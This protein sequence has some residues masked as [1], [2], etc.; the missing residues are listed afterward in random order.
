MHTNT[1][2]LFLPVPFGA[3]TLRNRIVM[4]PLT[5]SRSAANG[6]PGKYAAE[7]Y[8][9]RATAGL[10]IAEAAQI[11]AQG[12]GYAGAPGIYTAAHVRGW[13]MVTHAVHAAGGRIFLQLWHVGRISHPSLQPYGDLPVA[14]SAIQPAGQAF[15][16][17]GFQPFVTPRALTEGELP[18]IVEQYRTAAQRALD[19][20]FDGV[21]IHAANGY[22]ID[23]F[24]RDSTNQ[25][26]DAYGG[27]LEN[28]SRLLMEVTTAVTG[29]WGSH[30]V[31]VRLS[32]V[33]PVNDI[34]DSH[35]QSL[36]THVIQGLNG[37]KLLYVHMIEGATGGARDV[38][39]GF[40]FQ[41]LRRQFNG[42]Y[43]ANNGYDL[44][45]AEHNRAAG[46]LDLVAFGRLFISNPD[47]VRR[48]RLN[49]PLTAIDPDTV[50]GGGTHGY[51]DYPAWAAAA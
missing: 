1:T 43:I 7:Y 18:G 41:V 38:E 21:E 27:S 35:P 19:A 50:Y 4:A 10:I 17:E 28:R 3:C 31:G 14:P 16:E 47:L 15:T 2:D 30:R 11:S 20:G 46:Q 42:L 13:A 26:T 51:T 49:G 45:L 37:F 25:R 12:K 44:A 48:L 34:G 29:V 5:R 23:Q 40:D 9:Q 24:L 33:S 8:R 39:P 36:F 32:P 22:L 6:V